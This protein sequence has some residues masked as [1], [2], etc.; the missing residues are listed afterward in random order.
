MKTTRTL[1]IEQEAR[2]HADE[3][4]EWRESLESWLDAQELQ[5]GHHG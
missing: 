3:G 4:T 1:L 5:E 2:D